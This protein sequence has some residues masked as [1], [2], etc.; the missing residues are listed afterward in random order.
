M[1]RRSILSSWSGVMMTAIVD[2]GVFSSV[3]D[4]VGLVED[5]DD[6]DAEARRRGMHCARERGGSE[7]GIYSLGRRRG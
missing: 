2:E 6:V 5:E 3:V 4:A 1:R 7:D